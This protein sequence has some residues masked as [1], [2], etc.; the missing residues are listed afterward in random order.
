MTTLKQ[1]KP[2]F[3]FAKK[4]VRP[5]LTRAVVDEDT[6]RI[7]DLETIIEIKDNFGL[8]KGFHNIRTLGLTNPVSNDIED[9]PINLFDFDLDPVFTFP[10]TQKGIES[11]LPFCSTDETRLNLN[12]VAIN[13]GHIVA[14]DGHILKFEALNKEVVGDS[15]IMPS[16]SLIVLN[17]L[18]K[19]YKIKDTFTVLLNEEI[20]VVKND[21]FNFRAR[22]IQREYVQ[23]KR[24]LPEQYKFEFT[25]NN[26]L[27]VNELKPLFDRRN[28]I[29]IKLNKGIVI[30]TV[31]GHNKKYTIGQCPTDLNDTIGFNA[32]LFDIC[33]AKSVNDITVKFNSALTPM[34]INNNIG[35]PLKV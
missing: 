24:I 5:L 25:V 20:L 13:E 22:L 12:A 9:Y 19:K 29:T 17:K 8:E 26:W 11:F 3:N 14:T 16:D 28:A 7:T 4:Q 10:W 18:L 27:D 6:I 35:M 21:K 34:L 32:K 30:A 23:W 1:L 31:R 2:V 33:V 15:Y